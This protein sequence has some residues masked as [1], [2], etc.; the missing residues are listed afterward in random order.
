MIEK[1]KKDTKD[2]KHKRHIGILRL[3]GNFKC[4]INK[5][6]KSISQFELMK[7]H[8]DAIQTQY[9]VRLKFVGSNDTTIEWDDNEYWEELESTKSFIIVINQVSGRS[10]EWKCHP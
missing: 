3:P 2:A 7:L 1:L 10:T 5:E 4:H 8:K 6:K 9:G